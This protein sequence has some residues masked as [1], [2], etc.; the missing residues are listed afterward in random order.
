MKFLA[1]VSFLTLFSV[2]VFSGPIQSVSVCTVKNVMDDCGTSNHAIFSWTID[3]DEHTIQCFGYKAGDEKEATVARDA[4]IASV[5]KM[6]AAGL[7]FYI[8]Y[9]Y[10]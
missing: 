7:C 6:E 1:T 4:A 8:G 5:K 9:R 10:N 2:S 3:R